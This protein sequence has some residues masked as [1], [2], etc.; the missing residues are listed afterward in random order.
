VSS[1]VLLTA[2]TPQGFQQTF[3]SVPLA[4]RIVILAAIQL[5]MP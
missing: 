3:E 4:A 1:E 5:A 2:A